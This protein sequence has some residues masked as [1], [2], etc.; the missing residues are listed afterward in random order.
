MLPTVALRGIVVFPYSMVGFDVI[1]EKSIKA[2]EHALEKDSLIFLITQRSMEIENPTEL[3]LYKVG[4]VAKVKRIMKMPGGVVHVIAE[5]IERAGLLGIE[6][7]NPYMIAGVQTEEHEE[8]T[9]ENTIVNQAYS[10]SLQSQLEKYME[11]NQRFPLAIAV[12]P[13]EMGDL[14]KLTDVI[15]ANLTCGYFVKQEVLEI[16]DLYERAEKLNALLK[17][18]INILKYKKE[19]NDKVKD[20]IDENQR[21]YYLREEL[22][23]IEKELGDKDGYSEEIAKYRENI[24]KLGFLK[25]DEEKLLKETEKLAKMHG[26]S[27]DVAVIRNY[28]DCVLA[29]P[30]N[31]K[32]KEN[33]DINYASEILERD[34]YAMNDVKRRVLEHLAVHK[35]T[36]GK[37]GTVLCLSGP[38]GT[39]KTS[40]AK[41]IARALGREYVRVSLGGIHDEADIRG[42]RKTY[43]GSMPGRIMNAM[44]QA[45]TKNPLILLDELDKMGT[46]YKGDPS[47]ALLEVLDVE[48]NNA[49][50]DHYIEIPFDLSDVMFVATANNLSTVPA[51]L[52][53]RIE[54]IELS[55]Y[56]EEEKLN[57]AKKYLIPK[58]QKNN[59]L[60][61]MKLVFDD[62]AL[63]MIIQKYTRES[64]VRGLERKIAEMMR[65]IAVDVE[66]NGKKSVKIGKRNLLKYLDKPIY[67]FDLMN[68]KDEV[69]IVRGLAWTSVGGDTLSIEVNVME[70]SGKVELTGNL[71]DVMKESAMT[72]ISYV[73]SASEKLNIKDSFYK[74]KDIHI[75][76]PQGAVPKDG[77]SAG[78]TI[79][80]AVASALAE[81]PVRRDVAMTGEVTLRGKV[82]PIGGLKE[83]SL[84]A[85]R[86]GIKTVIIPEDNKR[87]IE[88]I[89]EEIR[90]EMDFVA[91]GSMETVIK[92][93]FAR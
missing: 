62:E 36:D 45:G 46:D 90:N 63:R 75:H 15:A 2:V 85:Y 31:K 70:G 60:K 81:I 92:A 61:D 51:P 35:L 9:L 34:H 73:R 53:D 19:I 12:E 74:T 16:Y 33:Q 87:D 48:Q 49:F 68:K 28:L 57:I 3:D 66:T 50:R 55:G 89:P 22:K 40:I 44:E 1:R 71:G 93:A 84:A 78:V 5:G 37:N 23:V 86:A 52:L 72:A 43:I 77:P 7:W 41:S 30:W 38:P 91:A 67:D 6:V 83:K 8:E 76:V 56:T 42:H 18:E 39:G 20:V 79:A 65:R 80:T 4:V 17:N 10:R 14:A 13:A 24:K 54:I 88:D 64:G 82:L 25:K 27:P 59:G 29:L 58:Q 47:S 26:S 21:E 32:S 69:G 11:Y